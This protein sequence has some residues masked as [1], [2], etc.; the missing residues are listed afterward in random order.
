MTDMIVIA[1]DLGDSFERQ[2]VESLPNAD[3][4]VA[5]ASDDEM[6]NGVLPQARV[7]V[8]I[9]FTERQIAQAR[10]LEWIHSLSAGVERL[11]HASL[12]GSG[13]TVTNASGAHISP[14]S[15]HV[16]AFMLCFARGLPEAFRQQRKKD[17]GWVQNDYFSPFLLEGATVTVIGLGN[18]GNAV[19]IKAHCLGM[20]VLG[21]RLRPSAYPVYI[22]D[23]G[24]PGRLKDFLPESD[25]VVNTLPLTK[26]TTQVIGDEEFQLMRPSAYFINVG[27]GRTVDQ[28]ALIEAL[29]NGSIA[30]AGLDVT[31][32][33]PLPKD[34]ALWD[35]EQVLITPHYSAQAPIVMD[36]VRQLFLENLVR[37]YDGR[38]LANVVDISAGY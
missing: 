35:M 15:E 6:L 11:P 27:R 8:G 38:P 26:L 29:N 36:R 24:G 37:F 34:S 31:D 3:I 7:L 23:L 1:H 17:W 13:I 25:F 22:D 10:R 12:A 18:L 14:I 16:L 5:I 20:K 9:R 4:E 21:V 32:P 33:E 2:I 30:G 28:E 19:A